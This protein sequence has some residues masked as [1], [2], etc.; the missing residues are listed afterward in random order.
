MHYG[1][2]LCTTIKMGAPT[3]Q[4]RL[5]SFSVELIFDVQDSSALMTSRLGM[6]SVNLR[7]ELKASRRE[8]L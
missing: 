3:L 6:I 2:Q 4:I 1:N 5:R 8:A 7:S